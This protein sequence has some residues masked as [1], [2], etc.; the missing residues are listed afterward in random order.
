MGVHKYMW[1]WLVVACVVDPQ[2]EAVSELC[3]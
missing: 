1:L 2:F 3:L